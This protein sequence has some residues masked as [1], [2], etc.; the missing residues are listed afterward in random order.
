MQAVVCC[1]DLSL[2]LS[3][4]QLELGYVS[5]AFPCRSRTCHT[6][7]SCYFLHFDTNLVM[8]AENVQAQVEILLPIKWNLYDQ[9]RLLNVVYSTINTQT[10]V[11]K[12]DGNKECSHPMAIIPAGRLPLR[13]TILDSLHDQTFRKICTIIGKISGTNC[14]RLTL[15]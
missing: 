7:N 11:W 15:W 1:Y 2:L 4:L 5:W 6:I 9:S 14:E 10:N 3:A 8:S 12:K 13:N